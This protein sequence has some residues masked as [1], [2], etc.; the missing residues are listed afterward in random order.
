M[1]LKEAFQAQNKIEELF[2]TFTGY[3]G[4]E[5]NVTRVIEK[6]FR[7]K[8]A[9][10]QID[11]TLDVTNYDL[12]IYDTNKVIDFL[13]V[14]IDER[15]KLAK[16]IHAAKS[17]MTFDIDTA[18]DV[19][20]KRHNAAG[21]LRELRQLK[22]KN[23]LRKNAGTGYVFNKDGNQTDFRYDVEVVTTID[24]DRNKVREIVKNL[25]IEA[26]KIS[27]EID[28]AL[29][30]TQVEYILPFDPHA[31]ATEILEEFNATK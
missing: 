20:K 31:S 21:V 9:D 28:A 27:A 1:N 16:A 7:S 14:L 2:N 13:L 22:S 19:N 24:F 15:E 4:I 10:A 29:I 11:E 30:N 26:D 23:L 17:K 3:L 8:A 12:K 18:V 5:R 6:H 25:Q